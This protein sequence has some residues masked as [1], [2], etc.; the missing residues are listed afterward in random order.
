MHRGLVLLA[1]AGLIIAAG[2]R[3]R[4]SSRSPVS[5]VSTSRPRR[6]HAAASNAKLAI[7]GFP[8]R[9]LTAIR[10][11]TCN[12]FPDPGV[13]LYKLSISVTDHTDPAHDNGI[14]IEQS[15]SSEP[16]RQNSKDPTNRNEPIKDPKERQFRE[17]RNE[18]S[19]R[20]TREK[21][22]QLLAKIESITRFHIYYPLMKKFRVTKAKPTMNAKSS[23]VRNILATSSNSLRSI[24]KV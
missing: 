8:A 23:K 10:E 13:P 24:S 5:V 2:S 15:N 9:S 21:A 22:K 18:R 17:L 20:R 16:R 19:E 3:L 6:P 4:T 12:D 14:D 1:C 11:A 7:T